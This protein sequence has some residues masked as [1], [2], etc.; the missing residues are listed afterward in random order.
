MRR[1]CPGRTVALRPLTLPR[2]NG[3]QSNE[4]IARDFLP[5]LRSRRPGT[6]VHVLRSCPTRRHSLRDRCCVVRSLL[7]AAAFVVILVGAGL[8]LP[9]YGAEDFA[10]HA[11]SSGP[12]IELARRH[13]HRR[14]RRRAAPRREPAH[15]RPDRVRSPV[16]DRLAADA[17]ADQAVRRDGGRRDH[18]WPPR[19]RQRRH[20]VARTRSCWTVGFRE[21]LFGGLG[22]R[23]STA[24]RRGCCEPS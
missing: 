14:A 20:L 16:R 24:R 6:H 13:R 8:T 15:P 2:V 11:L 23:R 9:Y 7:A 17:V 3:A 18:E 12:P 1:P 5:R 19:P 22:P 21:E 4:N 10:L